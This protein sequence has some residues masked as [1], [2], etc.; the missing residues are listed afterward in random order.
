[1]AAFVNAW[2]A[3]RRGDHNQAQRMFQ[4]RVLAQGFTVVVMC[5]GGIYLATERRQERELWKIQQRQQEEEKRQKWIRELEARDEED[6][7]VRELMNRRRK[8]VE[9]SS[10]KDNEAAAAAENDKSVLGAWGS[11]YWGKDGPAA[12]KLGRP[13]SS[14]ARKRSG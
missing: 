6:R 9:T 8:K 14:S 11:W 5:V 4:A 10:S 12:P 1:M 13:R 7:A 3:T 2:R